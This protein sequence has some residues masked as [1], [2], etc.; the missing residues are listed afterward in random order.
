MLSTR[1]TRMLGIRHPIV[2]AG[3]G[4][5]ARAELAAAVS[6]A[7]GLGML[8][9]GQTD[10]MANYAGQGVGLIREIL[11]AARIVERMVAEAEDLI[12]GGLPRLLA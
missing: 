6:N 11:P 9:K 12:R 7:G 8:G 1:L 2:Q 10:L 3:M 5:V 4:G